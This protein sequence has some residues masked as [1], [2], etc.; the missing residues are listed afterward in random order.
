[1]KTRRERVWMKGTRMH[2]NFPFQLVLWRSCH[3]VILVAQ[4]SKEIFSVTIIVLLM[5]YNVCVCVAYNL[6]SKDQAIHH[7]WREEMHGNIMADGRAPH[8]LS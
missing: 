5:T 7:E 6:L 1:M 8:S 2:T 4:Q 3:Y